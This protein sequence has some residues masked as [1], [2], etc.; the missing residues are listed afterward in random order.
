MTLQALFLNCSLKSSPRPSNTQA[1]ID[2]V[3][4]ILEG[5]QVETKT[6]RVADE[7]IAFGSGMDEGHGD[8]FPSLLKEIR[9]TDILVVAAPVWMGEMSSVAKMLHERLDATTYDLDSRNQREM[10]GKVGGAIAV[11]E[12]DGGQNVVRAIL[13]NLSIAGFTIPPNAD[14]FWTN[15]AG[16]GGPYLEADGD[17]SYYV[18]ERAR[19][20]A[21]NLAYFAQLLKEHP[22]PT[23][24][25]ALQKEAKV[26]GPRKKPEPS[27]D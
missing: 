25:K 11:G 16:P 4:G 24:L 15:E 18:N 8:G 3:A 14:C 12:G 19:Y 17:T 5:L 20:M 27:R 13:Y 10:Y 2:K 21:H 9:G 22:I 6:V 1:M 26:A 23:D 7:S